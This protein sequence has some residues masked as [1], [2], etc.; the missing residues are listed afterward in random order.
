M[1]II[2]SRKGFDSASGNQ[3]SPIMP[4]GTLLSLPIPDKE[5]PDKFS[6]LIF[7]GQ[8]LYEIIKDLKPRTKITE[9]DNCHL[10]PD[11]RKDLKPRLEG[12]LPAFGQIGASLTLLRNKGITE[13]DLFLFFGWFREVEELNGHYKYKRGA[14]DMHVMYGY[15]QIGSII[16]KKQDVPFWLSEHPHVGYTNSWDSGKNAI[17]LPSE[18][19][20]IIPEKDGAGLLKYREDRVLTKQ[21][22]SKSKWNLPDFFK[23]VDITCHPNPWKENY[24]QSTGRGQEFL[25]NA[26]PKIIEWAKDIIKD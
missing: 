22:M 19:L 3:P 16:N 26:T 6:S 24:F 11:L 13:G 5:S 12:W 9:N 7:N 18:H 14:H 17:F 1:K 4:D 15:M 8:S 20:S 25:M 10:D 21:G 2:L 23:E